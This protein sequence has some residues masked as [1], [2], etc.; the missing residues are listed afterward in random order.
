MSGSLDPLLEFWDNWIFREL[1]CAMC[2]FH[3]RNA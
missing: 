3:L 1:D 2:H